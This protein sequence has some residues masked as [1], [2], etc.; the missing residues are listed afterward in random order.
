MLC[1]HSGL[2]DKLSLITN[3]RLPRN[4]IQWCCVA[5]V[6]NN[7]AELFGVIYKSD[8]WMTHVHIHTHSHTHKHIHI[9]I[10]EWEVAFPSTHVV[11]LARLWFQFREK[12]SRSLL[13]RSYSYPIAIP[14]F[15]TCNVPCNHSSSFEAITSQMCNTNVI[16]GGGLNL[17]LCLST[18]GTGCEIFRKDSCRLGGPQ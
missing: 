1:Y 5:H 14:L 17:N 10:N 4:V 7:R 13:E 8:L 9:Y 6:C 18:L 3:T 11:A 2:L 12:V 15:S 16:I